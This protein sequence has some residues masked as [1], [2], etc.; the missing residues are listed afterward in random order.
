MQ[1]LKLVWTLPTLNFVVAATLLLWGYQEPVP[2]GSEVYAPTV[3]LICWGMNAPALLLRSAGS[4]D[5]FAWIPE[6]TFGLYTSDLLFLLGVIVLWSLV[7]KQ[8]DN[9]LT[10]RNRAEVSVPTTLIWRSLQLAMAGLLLLFGLDY[11][12]NPRFNNPYYPVEVVLAS[13]WA[14]V[15]IF[16]ATKALTRV[17]RPSQPI[18]RRLG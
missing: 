7:G 6:P 17:L 11:L 5:V 13:V 9:S 2:P 18:T 8:L 16:V 14:A 10:S 12:R 4:W 3:W 15:L 1:K